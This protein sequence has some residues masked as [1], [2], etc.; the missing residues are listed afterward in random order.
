MFKGDGSPLTTHE[1]VLTFEADR[2]GAW[3]TGFDVHYRTADGRTG[4][5]R[6]RWD[7]VACGSAIHDLSQCPKGSWG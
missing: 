3:I 1:F 6:E 2:R 7:V 5:A 4:V